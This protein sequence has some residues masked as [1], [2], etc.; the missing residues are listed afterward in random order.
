[1]QATLV[2]APDLSIQLEHAEDGLEWFDLSFEMAPI[3]FAG[4]RVSVEPELDQARHREFLSFSRWWNQ[5][6]F[7]V[8]PGNLEVTRRSLA[9]A[10]ADKDGG[11]HVDSELASD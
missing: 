8:P 7:V 4:G 5:T 3:T 6:V 11:A 10:A 2:S 1:M 9:L